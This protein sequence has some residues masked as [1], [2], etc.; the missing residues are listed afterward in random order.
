MIVLYSIFREVKVIIKELLKFINNVSDIQP[1]GY[2]VLDQSSVFTS[3]FHRSNASAANVSFQPSYSS[4]VLNKDLRKGADRTMPILEEISLEN[5]E[6]TPIPQHIDRRLADLMEVSSIP[7][8][9]NPSNGRSCNS[10]VCNLN[11][12]GIPLIIEPDNNDNI[13]VKKSNR[14][15]EHKDTM[16]LSGILHNMM[17]YHNY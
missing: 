14:K 8:S 6:N 10:S 13:D 5:I 3:P 2:P 9:K 17:W 7:G 1:A 12:S 4:K 15:N 11:G 16:N